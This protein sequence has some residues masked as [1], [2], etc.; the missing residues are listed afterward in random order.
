MRPGCPVPAPVTDVL[1]V[2]VVSDL[3]IDAND[4]NG[5]VVP[6]TFAAL[7][8][9]LVVVVVELVVDGVTLRLEAVPPL[10]LPTLFL[11]AWWEEVRMAVAVARAWARRS[12]IEGVVGLAGLAGEGVASVE[13]GKVVRG[14]LDFAF[15][16]HL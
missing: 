14:F 12:S 8:A 2:L 5:F 1:T 7:V 16:N 6:E 13:G 15:A 4:A 3:N 11:L 9:G 10:L